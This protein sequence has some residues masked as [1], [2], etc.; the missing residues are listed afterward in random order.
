M[1]LMNE[2]IQGRTWRQLF[3]SKITEGQVR[4]DR[5]EGPFQMKKEANRQI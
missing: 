2:G 1:P 5:H 4:M 3:A